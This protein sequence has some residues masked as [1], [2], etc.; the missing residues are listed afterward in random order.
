MSTL[1]TLQ[2]ILIDEFDLTRE[3]VAPDVELA[4]LGVD[5]DAESLERRIAKTKGENRNA[6]L[7]SWASVA[8]MYL[9]V[10]WVRRDMV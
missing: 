6:R 4:A 5:V 9:V 7:R 3:R 10:L 2:D 8:K 1:E